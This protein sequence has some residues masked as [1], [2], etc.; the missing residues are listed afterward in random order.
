M[1]VIS[2]PLFLFNI[3]MNKLIT[4]I[5]CFIIVIIGLH[6]IGTCN[7]NNTIKDNIINEKDSN[8]C[9]IT[10]TTNILMIE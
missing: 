9:K 6:I 5:F 8:V 2:L 4:C 1:I 10:D 3:D 7:Y